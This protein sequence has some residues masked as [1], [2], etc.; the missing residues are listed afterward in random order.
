[1]SKEAVF[2]QIDEIVLRHSQ[3]GMTVLRQ[4]QEKRLCEAAAREILSWKKG[5]ILLATG[6]YVAG[7]AETDGPAGTMV[8]AKALKSLGYRPVVI[9]DSYCRGFF[10]SEE[11]EAEYLPIAASDEDCLAV[12]EKYQPEGMISIERCGK[13]IQ[14]DYANMRGISIAK[15]TAPVDR[16]FELAGPDALLGTHRI[17]TIGVGD[18]GNEIGMGKLKDVITKDLSLVPCRVSADILVTASVS[19]WGAY[20]IAAALQELTGEVVYSVIDGKPVSRKVEEYIGMTVEIGSVDGVTHERVAHVDGYEA[21]VEMEILDAL[22]G[23]V[24]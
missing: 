12:I 21:E 5:T 15:N 11:I 24:Q 7:Y 17:P 23:V 3:R 9:T 8:M 2:D 16:I 20:G 10:E 14:N 1:M 6:F 19:N 22:A 18:G 4:H 13:N